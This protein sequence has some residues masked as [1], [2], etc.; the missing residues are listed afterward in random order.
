MITRFRTSFEPH[1]HSGL[2]LVMFLA[3]MALALL[4]FAP[5]VAGS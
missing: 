5:W 3:L 2:V 4:L 1:W